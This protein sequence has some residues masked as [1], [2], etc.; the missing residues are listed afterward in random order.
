MKKI[1]IT[2]PYFDK[3]EERAVVDVLRSGWVTQG[4]RVAEFEEAVEKF[5]GTKYAVATTSATTSL[6]LALYLLGVGQGDEVIVPSFS[7]IATA[8][9]IRHTGATP[10]FVDIDPNT[11]NIDPNLIESKITKNTKAIIPVDQLGLPCE[12]DAINRIAK[13]HNL[14]VV[15]DAACSL[16]SK[17]KGKSIGGYADLTCFSFHP[18]KTITCGEG[19]MI[20]TNN[21]EWAERAKLLR[22]HG[23]GVSDLKRHSAKSV[24]HEDYVEAGFNFRMTDL[25]AAVGVEQMKK[26]PEILRKRK[27]LA[28][29]YNRVF[30]K[31]KYLTP[32]YVADYIDYNY[33]SYILR[34]S[35]EAKITRDELLQKL[36][37]AGI[38]GKRG[39]MAIH[40][41]ECY[42]KDYPNVSLPETEE[43]TDHTVL[44]PLYSQ[45]STSDQ[46]YVIEQIVKFVG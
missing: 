41:E 9:V 38:A 43:A 15:Q 23:M 40:R 4:P 34:L 27:A 28:K 19:G 35:R 33:Q 2:I 12:I 20:V 39:V 26:F 32:V 18:R 5:T 16:G 31:H 6:F 22:H 25:Q 11:Y 3:N 17:Y 7:F 46:D 8:N 24:V 29:R 45:M 37:D 13:K 21:K 42:L 36:L 44:I 14:F 1:P 10:V 30:S